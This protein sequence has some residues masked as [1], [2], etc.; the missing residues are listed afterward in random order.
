M[1]IAVCDDS[2][3][4]QEQIIRVLRE[5]DPE[6]CPESFVSGKDLLE[7][8]VR[9]PLFDIAFIDI[10]LPGEDGVDI[11]GRVRTLS[12]S[13]ELVFVTSSV[14]HAVDA[15]SLNAL[16]YLVKP[17][18][19]EDIREVFRR[20][21]ELRGRK[22][23]VVS[24]PVS[25]GK[26]TVFL[27]EISYIQSV[28]HIKEIHLTDGRT[29]QVWTSFDELKEKLGEDFLRLNRSFLV[30]MDQIVRMDLNA[31]YLQE[32][33][34][35]EFARRERTAIRNAYDRY[36]FARLNRGGGNTKR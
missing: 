13:T 12:P 4:E 9:K 28:G 36:L 21:T 32:G 6:F 10:Y 26:Y 25:N 22:R 23:P 30:N 20:L 29:L 35:L 19:I 27:D 16:H 15:F 33:I 24:L 1:R 3:R 14:D 11:A 2:I 17:V 7:A 34:R 18:T 31:C 5:Y 8:A